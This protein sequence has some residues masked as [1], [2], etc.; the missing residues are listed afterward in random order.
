VFAGNV[1]R[2]AGS[3]GFGLWVGER[4]LVLFHDW[5]GTVFTYAYTLGGYLVMLSMLLAAR[6]RRDQE[7]ENHHVG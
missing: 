4:S 7:L 3:L 1:L 5:V 6:Q 2:L